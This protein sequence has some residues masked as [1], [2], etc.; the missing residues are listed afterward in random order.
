VDIRS[1]GAHVRYYYLAIQRLSRI[2]R[3]YP[4]VNPKSRERSILLSVRPL[5]YSQSTVYYMSVDVWWSPADVHIKRQECTSALKDKSV[6]P[7]VSAYVYTK[8]QER[9]S[10]N[11]SVH[12]VQKSNFSKIRFWLILVT[13]SPN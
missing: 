5:Y 7:V 3:Y 10:A 13:Q 2:S 9:I 11:P 6:R 8:R 1:K 4:A 12:P